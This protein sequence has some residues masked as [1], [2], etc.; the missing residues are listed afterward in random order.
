MTHRGPFQP[1]PF[2]DSVIFVAK[3]NWQNHEGRVL[4]IDLFKLLLNIEQKRVQAQFKCK[5]CSPAP[6]RIQE[7]VSE[8]VF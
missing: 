8:I 3:F 4:C 6:N 7:T 5:M 1:L 2:C